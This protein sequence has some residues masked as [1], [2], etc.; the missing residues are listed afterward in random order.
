MELD[1]GLIVQRGA[2]G[3]RLQVVDEGSSSHSMRLAHVAGDERKLDSVLDEHR[4]AERRD[5]YMKERLNC[6]RSLHVHG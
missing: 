6:S 3:Q 5:E 1:V 4:G 2:E